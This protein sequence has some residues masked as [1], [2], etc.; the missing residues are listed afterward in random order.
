[1]ECSI[2]E[3]ASDFIILEMTLTR[4]NKAIN[5]AKINDTENFKKKMNDILSH[6]TENIEQLKLII[7]ETEKY[8][9]EDR[10]IP[11]LIDERK[12]CEILCEL[13][14]LENMTENIKKYMGK[15]TDKQKDCFVKFLRIVTKYIEMR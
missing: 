10:A 1:M 2:V 4:L 6:F 3:S 12:S 13:F 7:R 15:M 8:C 14:T 11:K 5:K 9:A